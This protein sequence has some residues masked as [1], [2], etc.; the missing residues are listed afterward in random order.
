MIFAATSKRWTMSYKKKN[1]PL[2]EVVRLFGINVTDLAAYFDVSRSVLSMA[3]GRKRELPSQLLLHIAGWFTALN[4]IGGKAPLD[5][6]DLAVA[7][8]KAYFE[9][10][11]KD[12]KYQIETLERKTAAMETAAQ[13]ACNALWL[14][15]ETRNGG[16]E[17][18][19]GK[20]DWWDQ[21]ESNAA[22]QLAENGPLAQKKKAIAIATAQ[23]EI[24]MAEDFLAALRSETD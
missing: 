20:S 9:Q 5:Q 3:A 4:K 6:G 23:L 13:T 10:L 11:I 16:V 17:T 15:G 14:V 8:E 24:K 1:S 12:K 2:G 7:R 22:W 19:A 18:L 21:V